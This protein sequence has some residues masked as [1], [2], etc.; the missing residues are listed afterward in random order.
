M[1]TVLTTRH[2]EVIYCDDIRLEEGGKSSL[3]GVYSGDLITSRLPMLLPKL[4]LFITVITPANQPFELLDVRVEQNGNI[5]LETGNILDA[6]QVSEF[7]NQLDSDD[8]LESQKMIAFNLMF[9]LSPFKVDSES[10]IRV[11]A[12]TESGEYRGRELRV[13]LAQNGA[14]D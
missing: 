4:C 10:K 11:V 6:M 12:K 2:V 5:L 13:R 1:T 14:T 9:T 7:P 8:D 3:M